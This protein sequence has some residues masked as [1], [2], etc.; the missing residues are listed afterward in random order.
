MP[1]RT[2]RPD[3]IAL[4]HLANRTLLVDTQAG[5]IFRGDG[6]TRAERPNHD[7]YG[8]VYLGRIAGK[9]RWGRAHRIVWIAAHGPIPGLYEITHRNGRRWDNRITNL[10]I[11][12]HAETIRIAQ[13]GAMHDS[14]PEDRP[15][16][17]PCATSGDR[18]IPSRMK[19]LQV[20]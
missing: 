13:R 11:V 6:T 16:L 7:A 12:R 10:D 15:P 19:R 20:V 3:E 2:S 9:I 4:W 5:T 18:V 17:N 8:S 14:G 1:T